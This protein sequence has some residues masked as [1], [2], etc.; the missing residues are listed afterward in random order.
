MNQS[1]LSFGIAVVIPCYKVTQHIVKV[2]ADMPAWVERIY[3]VD[4]CC[5][6]YSG[7]FIENNIQDPRL[8]VIYNEKNKGVGGAVMAGY[9]SAIK[10]GM[11]VVVKVDGDGQMDP[12][13]MPDFVQPILVGEADYTKG[14]RFY[15]LEEISQMPK[16][17]LFGNAVLSL[18]N[19][20]SSGYWDVFDPTNGYTAV[21]VDVLKKLPFEKISE[22]YFFESDMLF[23]LNTIRAKV[24]DVPMDASYGDE[25]SNL[26]IS[27]IVGEFT[28]KNI[29]NTL[30]RVFYNYYLRDMSVASIELLLAIP[31]IIFGVIYGGMSWME[32]ASKG[33]AT[34]AGTVMMA[35]LPIIVGI[36]FLL[37]FLSYD[38][39]NVPRRVI[40]KRRG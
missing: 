38:I 9:R 24:V 27:K 15:N 22:R 40:H 31:L 6:D 14:N 4:D 28:R 12:A 19:K 23:R 5:P 7:K 30:K 35:V 2:V 29:K 21:H 34:P 16:V 8:Q 37:S 33:V 10:D 36:Q 26:K 13:L 11:R 25:E 18:M 20:I 39:E 17:R 3:A 1:E 32:S